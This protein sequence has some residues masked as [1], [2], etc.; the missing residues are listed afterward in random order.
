MPSPL[1]PDEIAI[2]DLIASW[3]RAAEASDYEGVFSLIID[4]AV[5]LIAGLF[6]FRS[7]R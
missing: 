1:S 2:R 4:D 6:P 3:V 7:R 5:M